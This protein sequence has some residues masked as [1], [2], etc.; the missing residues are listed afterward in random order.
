M[1]EA[2]QFVKGAISIKTMEPVLKHFRIREGHV[3]AY[4]GLMCLSSP[5]ECDL[6]VQPVASTFIH[7]I[8]LCKETVSLHLT[9]TG[10][11][12]IK[13]GRFKA[14]IDCSLEA[15]PGVSP[16]GNE[17][18]LDGGLLEAL[19][20]LAPVMGT[21][22]SRPWSHGVMLAGQS[23][24]VTNNIVLVEKWLGYQLPCV[25]GLPAPCVKELLRINE[26]PIRVQSNEKTV[27]FH[28]EGGRWLTSAL[29][30]VSEWP[31]PNQLFPE[32]SNFTDVDKS[33]FTALQELSPFTDELNSVWFHEDGTISTS[34]EDD[35]GAH[36]QM[37]ECKGMCGRYSADQF[38]KVKDI[39]L[40]I[41]WSNYPKP[42]IFQGDGLRGVIIGLA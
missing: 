28:F 19:R 32:E 38:L 6:D 36:L 30:R 7:A 29:L 3:R 26:E 40:R 17:I 22:A 5:I 8:Q 18:N 2:L 20:T 39:A 27:A 10:R 12:A 15:F 13:S 11:L 24:Y 9:E 33:L 1:L 42:C 37:T 35:V 34:E 16:I 41:D 25:L 31:D 23:A 14:F 21:D 4:N